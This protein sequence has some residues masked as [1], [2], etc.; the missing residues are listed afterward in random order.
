MEKKKPDLFALRQDLQTVLEW[1]NKRTEAVLGG[2]K[3]T[4]AELAAV[5]ES[6]ARLAGAGLYPFEADGS[7]EQLWEQVKD[8]MQKGLEEG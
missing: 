8:F 5:K 6:C 4:E 1:G 2:Q 7:A 3:P